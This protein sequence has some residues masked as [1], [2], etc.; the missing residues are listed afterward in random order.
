MFLGGL[1]LRFAPVVGV[2]PEIGGRDG[3]RTHDPGVANAVLSQ[4]SYSPTDGLLFNIARVS[5]GTRRRSY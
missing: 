2:E 5:G 1:G 3:I 4:L